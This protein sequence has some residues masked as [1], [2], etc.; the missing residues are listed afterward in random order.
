MARDPFVPFA[1]YAPNANGTPRAYGPFAVDSMTRDDTDY[2]LLTITPDGPWPTANPL[3]TGAMTW[4]DGS[5]S[6]FELISPV[7]NRFGE[8][9][10]SFTRSFKVRRI[11]NENVKSPVISGSLSFLVHAAC[12]VS[13]R[14]QALMFVAP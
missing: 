9:M 11:G 5:G 10:P 12:R 7:R 6:G 14:L 8:I 2:L 13:V 4:S 1:N 3:V